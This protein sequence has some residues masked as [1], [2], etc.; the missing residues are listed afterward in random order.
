MPFSFMKFSFIQQIRFRGDN[1]SLPTRFH[2]SQYNGWINPHPSIAVVPNLFR[3]ATPY[4]E[5][6]STR[7]PV[8]HLFALGF[9]DSL[10]MYF[11]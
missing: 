7:H 10:K 4:R 8:S 2:E 1:A 5:I 3:L 11:F 9:D 6:Y